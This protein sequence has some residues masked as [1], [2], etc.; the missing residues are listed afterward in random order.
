MA[1]TPVAGESCAVRTHDD[2]TRP[3]GL[4]YFHAIKDLA[5]GRMDGFGIGIY[6]DPWAY[7]QFRGPEIPNYWHWAHE[8]AISDHFHA[9]VLGPSYPNH[10]SFIAGTSGGAVENPVNILGRPLPN[11]DELISWG[12]SGSTRRVSTS[13]RSES[14]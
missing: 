10:F 6:G 4:R 9:S 3:R 13:P 8:Y 12:G 11:G 2:G 5:G 7:T 1:L 14:N